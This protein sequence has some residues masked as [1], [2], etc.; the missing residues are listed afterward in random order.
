[1]FTSLF[2]RNKSK[3]KGKNVGRAHNIKE[4]YAQEILNERQ[5]SR[6]LLGVRDDIQESAPKRK[7]FNMKEGIEDVI[8]Q[9]LDE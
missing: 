1:L 2:H 8:R 5:L 4:I 9:A 6:C 3:D 7:R